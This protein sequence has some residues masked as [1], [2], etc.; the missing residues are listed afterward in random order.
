[1]HLVEGGEGALTIGDHAL[2]PE[3]LIGGEEVH[4][5]YCSGIN[6]LSHDVRRVMEETNLLPLRYAVAV[7]YG[8]VK[9][10]ALH[11]S[12]TLEEPIL[13]FFREQHFAP[14]IEK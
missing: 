5:G 11:T 14:G 12:Q 6:L 4:D 13:S 3:M 2:M 1:M 7:L 10:F 8:K 9:V